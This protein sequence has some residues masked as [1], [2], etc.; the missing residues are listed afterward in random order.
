MRDSSEDSPEQVN[1][2]EHATNPVDEWLPLRWSLPLGIQHL[3]AACAS[4]VIT[5]LVLAGALGWPEEQITYLISAG[6]LGTGIA[7]LIQVL[8]IPGIAV[9]T[10]L[11]VIQGTTI[12]VIPPLIAIGQTSDIT[13]MFGATI[14]AGSVCLLL[15]GVWSRLLHLFPPVVTGTVITVI[16]VSLFPVAVMWLSGGAGFGAQATSAAEVGLGLSTLLLVLLLV[17]YGNNF[18]SRTAILCGLIFGSIAAAAFDMGNFSGVARA[19]WLLLPLPFAYGLPGFTVSACVAM[20]LAMLVTMVESTGDYIAIGE[21]CEQKVDQ[22]RLAAGLRAE[23][24]GTII[25]GIF[26][27]FP[28]TTFSQNIGVIRVSGV[29]SRYVVAV[30]GVMFIGLSLA[31]K[32][33]AIVSNIPTPVLGGCGLVLF[34]SIAATGIQTLRKV[35]FEQTG[36]LITVGVSLGAAMLVV[37]NPIYFAQLPGFLP[38]ILNN[39]IT[40]GGVS[41]VSLNLVFNGMKRPGE[42]LPEEHSA[43][44]LSRKG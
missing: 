23:G 43:L 25:G 3:L 44:D 37:A 41:A 13:V 24:I 38:D 8:G 31:P 2:P 27:A 28:Y 29:R 36:N 7:T 42:P 22:K 26:N 20:T 6:L 35:D 1:S 39:P 19:D 9:G 14:F 34:G 40:L 30:T 21:V 17:R 4:I 33:A 11:P 32:A 10:K 18:L 16:G 15:A 12:A 5:P